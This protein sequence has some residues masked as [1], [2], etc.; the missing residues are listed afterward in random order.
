[1]SAFARGLTEAIVG[2]MLIA[3]D[4][5]LPMIGI[6]LTASMSSFLISAGSGLVLGGIGTLLAKGPLTGLSTASRNPIAPWNVI[7]GRSRMGGTMV[8]VE[9]TGESD[10]Y[11][12]MVI[13][14]ACHPC[15][16]IDA[17]LFDGKRVCLDTSNNSLSFDDSTSVIAEQ[18][19]RTL[20]KIERINGTVTATMVSPMP[21][22][23]STAAGPALADG[24]QVLIHDVPGDPTLN[25]IYAIAVVN[26]TTFTYICPGTDA[27]VLSAGHVTTTWADYGDTVHM[28]TLLGDHTATF[29]GLLATD[30]T[31]SKG[32]WTADHLLLG[33][34]AVYLRLKYGGNTY[35]SGLPAIAF[36]LHG[37]KDIYDPRTSSSGYTE[38]AALCI[39]DYLANTTWGF[40]A[41]YATEIPYDPL[42]AAANLCDEDVP[43]ASG[44]T[45]KR[46]ACNGTFPLT[47]KRGEVLQN[48]L[49]SCGGRLT[50]AAGQF[51]IHP[52]AWPGVSFAI[53]APAI[54]SATVYIV[55]EYQAAVS[56]FGGRTSA[57]VGPTAAGSGWHPIIYASGPYA[58]QTNSAGLS[59]AEI[60]ELQADNLEVWCRN[61]DTVFVTNSPL[62][63]SKSLI[64]D[65][66]IEATH[67]DGSTTTYR[68][69][70]YRR[71]QDDPSVGSIDNPAAAID[72]DDTTAATIN[73]WLFHPLL[74]YNIET[75]VLSTFTPVSGTAGPDLSPGSM[76]LS[77]QALAQSAGPFQWRSKVAIRD[78]YNGVKGTFISPLNNWQSSDI[79][80]YC[81]DEKH[82]YASDAN[83][84]ADG[85]DRRWLDIQL[86]FT[87]SVATAQ[88]LAKIELLR[89]RHQGTGTFAF[90]LALYKAAALDV[91][92]F[93]LPLLGWN[94]KL[95]EI[96]AHRFT[97]SKQQNADGSEVT[98][99]GTE[100]DLQETD[101]SV[102]DWSPGEELTSAGFGQSAALPD[103]KTVAAPTSV[104]AT[105]SSATAITGADGISRSRVLVSWAPP[106]D[107]YV[108]N[109]G[110]VEVQYER[111]GDTGWTGLTSV[112]PSVTQLYID[113]VI[114]GNAYLVQ[115]RFV[116]TAGA[117][118][119][120]VTAGPVTANG[121]PSAIAP[122]S[123][124]QAGATTG[125][126]LQWNGTTWVPAPPPATVT[127]Q[128]D[129]VTNTLQSKLNLKSGANV[130][131]TADSLGG[132]TI[133]AAGSSTTAVT[134]TPAGTLNGSN[135]TFTLS[136]TPAT[137][138]LALWLNGV[139]QVPTTDYTSS[140]ATVTFTVAPRSSDLMV[141][142]YTH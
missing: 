102:Y 73:R 115:V 41:N 68:P 20:A 71:E 79:P 138:S 62:D 43:L 57:S 105:S 17:L 81:Q 45:E 134:Q 128:T 84:A 83:L 122:S 120:W 69:R 10:K 44:T 66:W 117:A 119:S 24:D 31:G 80:P 32:L 74:D 59:P 19:T 25:G 107:G 58:K 140:G 90:N 101:P 37:K 11:L 21:L 133:A 137:G 104:T 127:F 12:Q 50:Y 121:T 95:L 125:E 89:R 56:G 142:E 129:S 5:F 88:R 82:G 42:I 139:E 64:Y 91:V 110:H 108:T 26:A 33:K 63:P 18:Q 111:V 109:G 28:E 55:T 131:L 99:L 112:D 53:G 135:R 116:N 75:L 48:L 100:L 78:L 49:T 16:S 30:D 96:A 103:V 124:T 141:A 54:S 132:V 27:T 72:G 6:A 94:A 14:L 61:F 70:S 126:I 136:Y 87:V 2:A 7:Y 77:G 1:M 9:E 51:V 67:P 114:D 23:A 52:A 34:T 40:K 4:I 8:F 22:P 39:A 15:Q 65:C 123:I 118:S 106:T 47:T 97:P 36:L 85:G 76:V 46:Y 113:G 60:A 35:A 13:V 92:A 93:T 98:L 130:T 29:P 86:P 38:N 3:L